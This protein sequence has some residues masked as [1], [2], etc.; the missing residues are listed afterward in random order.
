MGL[1]DSIV[2]QRE[3]LL[4]IWGFCLIGK[5]FNET[6][7]FRI[8]IELQNINRVTKNESIFV[9]FL[10]FNSLIFSRTKLYKHKISAFHIF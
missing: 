4:N 8:I 10:L 9:V 2:K 7:V 1:G 6:V 5:A 3:N